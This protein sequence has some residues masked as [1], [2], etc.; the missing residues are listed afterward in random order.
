V[1]F[2]GFV[3]HA[4]AATFLNP[5]SDLVLDSCRQSQVRLLRWPADD[6]HEQSMWGFIGKD[7][8]MVG[9]AF[10]AIIRGKST[11]RAAQ[12]LRLFRC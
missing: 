11:R 2:A 12:D 4:T 10:S 3:P 7:M 5:F 6:P 1:T 8:L 9:L